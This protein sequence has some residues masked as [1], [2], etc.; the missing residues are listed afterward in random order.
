MAEIQRVQ[1]PDLG[2]TVPQTDT[3]LAGQIAREQASILESQA[4]AI[5]ALAQANITATQRRGASLQKIQNTFANLDLRA[6]DSQKRSG[7]QSLVV[8]STLRID[9]RIQELMNRPG[10][11]NL[12]LVNE[13]SAII[14]E[15]SNTAIA[16]ARGFGKTMQ[17]FVKTKMENVRLNRIPTV[18][19]EGFKRES[20]SQLANTT[21]RNFNRKAELYAPGTSEDRKIEL[22]QDI[23]ADIQALEGVHL[24]A[25]RVEA[26]IQKEVQEFKRN[27]LLGLAVED[28]VA[29]LK[30]LPEMG[31][32]DQEELQLRNQIGNILA[33]EEN[34]RKQEEAREA[35]EKKA[36]AEST[37]KGVLEKMIF[38]DGD[39]RRL[40]ADPSQREALTGSQLSKLIRF[41]S[42]LVN[43]A[44]SELKDDPSDVLRLKAQYASGRMN[45]EEIATDLTLELRAGSKVTAQEAK[46]LMNEGMAAFERERGIAKTEFQRRWQDGEENIKRLLAFETGFIVLF[47]KNRRTQLN[48]ALNTALDL[49]RSRLGRA[50]EQAE[51]QQV[52]PLSLVR[53]SSIANEILLDQ[54]G[55]VLEALPKQEI[56]SL[57][58]QNLVS[59]TS[60]ERTPRELNKDIATQIQSGLL[61]PEEGMAI[62]QA[63]LLA[64]EFN[65]IQDQ[66]AAAKSQQQQ[67]QQQ[68]GRP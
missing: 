17:E 68:Q 44:K 7:A 10:V 4:R 3:A 66:L 48:L 22:V 51:I 58:F 57:A 19:R 50:L 37:M 59:R 45:P 38:Q 15:E 61:T 65:R 39:P 36:L 20:E 46:S 63:N 9:R 54:L 40:L 14:T 43:Q 55:T 42:S 11:N 33:L 24:S 60:L 31:F 26:Q 41:H 29:A 16:S 28:P 64:V 32:A 49:Y 52:P 6:R 62:R 13:A 35:K 8:D 56:N 67:Q 12:D 47:E 25:D 5:T 18:R 21:R 34:K 27:N 23:V 53:P 2:V 1:T 30:L